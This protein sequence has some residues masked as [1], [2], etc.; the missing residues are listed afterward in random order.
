MGRHRRWGGVAMEAALVAV[1]MAG[2]GGAGPRIVSA[3]T[4]T[5]TYPSP[6]TSTSPSPSSSTVATTTATTATT[7]TTTTVVR[8]T[9]V[10]PVVRPV[11]TTTSR[12]VAT[13]VPPTPPTT[14]GCPTTLAGTL[15]STGGGSQLVTVEAAGTGST[16]G[17]VTLWQRSG[18]CWTVAAGPWTGDLGY[19]GLSTD[20][21]EG[22]GTTPSGLY[23]ISSTIYGIA[24]NPGV[25]GSYHQLVCGDWW[26]EDPTSPEYNTFQH[27]ACGTT[28]PFGGSSEAL[29]EQTTAY[30][31][32]AFI[33]YNSGPII[34]GNGSA[35]FIHDDVGGPTHGCI[36]LPPTDLETLLRWLEPSQSP[37][38]ALGTTSDIRQY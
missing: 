27:L 12:P 25:H 13:T 17:T 22:D 36:S 19:Q 23:G 8:T 24:A 2:C 10:R 1:V 9:V 33:E 32:F 30:Q 20:H 4:T 21:R 37:H 18:T 5:S 16:S 35:I 14:A 11:T 15:A 31:H 28:P 34:P 38:I 29:W 7:T 6:S 26:D 3:D